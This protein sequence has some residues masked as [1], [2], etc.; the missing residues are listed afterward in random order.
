MM[1]LYEYTD[2]QIERNMEER[3]KE[4]IIE[5]K[6]LMLAA[7]ALIAREAIIKRA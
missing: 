5:N 6:M 4:D 7:S 3:L 1:T 2:K